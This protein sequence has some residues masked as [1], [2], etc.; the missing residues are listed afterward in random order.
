MQSSN[1]VV[2]ANTVAPGV[3][4]NTSAPNPK[5]PPST[6]SGVCNSY[7]PADTV[8]NRLLYVVNY[9]TTNG[10][11]VV[12]DNQLNLDTTALT[13]YNQWVSRVSHLA[14]IS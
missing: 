1:S 10:F 2:A 3:K 8:V 12:L 9:F 13:N 11:Y 4:P 14:L 5:K 6:V 7:V